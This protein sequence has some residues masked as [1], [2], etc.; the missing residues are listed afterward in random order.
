MEPIK[1][2]VVED[3]PIT[4]R[5]LNQSLKSLGYTVSATVDCAEDAL[6]EVSKIQPD[7]V[8]MDIILKGTLDGIN[9]ANIIRQLYNIPVIF[10]TAYSDE[11]TLQRAGIT[12]PF[13]YLLKPFD[14]RE[15]HSSIQI[16]LRRHQVEQKMRENLEISE[17]L[18]QEA[19]RLAE[20]KS[21]YISMTSHEFR[22][23]M[24]TIQGSTELLQYYSHRWTDEKKLIHY[25]RIKDAVKRMTNLLDEVLMIG[26][27]ESG[28]LPFN[29]QPVNLVIFCQNLAEEQELGNRTDQRIRIT[30]R[31]YFPEGWRFDENLL[32]HILTNLLSNAIKY[33]PNGEDVNF[34]ITGKD[35]QV[36]FEIQD[37]GIG[38]PAEELDQLFESFE[39]ATNVGSIPGTGLGLAIVKK[40]VDAHGG[41]I[42]VESIQ[43]VGTTFTVR[44][45]C[46]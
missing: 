5:D 6:E 40:C 46:K 24:T 4:A 10:L 33:S 8:L 9:L 16:A 43:D 1:I 20:V 26:K 3:E 28:K 44:L 42:S 14:E 35:N 39:R 36:V 13:G 2:L 41:T 25:Q 29:P 45:P 17:A 21:R 11:E 15:I 32:R 37:R 19:E 23:P 7:L 27:A 12:E 38:I 22:T 34:I 31:G 30:L 18:R